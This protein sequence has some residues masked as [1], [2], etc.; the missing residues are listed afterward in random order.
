LV[1][2]VFLVNALFLLATTNFNAGLLL[3]VILG[4]VMLGWGL[5][6]RLLPKA[7]RRLATAAVALAFFVPLGFT[8]GLAAYGLNDNVTG[9]EDAIV[10]LGAAVHGSV[11]SLALSGR[12][13]AAFRLHQANPDALIVV[14]G[15]QGPQEDRA[16]AD[17]MR[18]YLVAWGVP[19]ELIVTEDRATSTA[20]NFAF[21]R[22]LLDALLPPGYTVVYVTHESHVYRAGLIAADAGLAAHHAHTLSTWYVWPSRYLRETAAVLKTWLLGP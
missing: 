20:E 6:R 10:V 11:P 21:S 12:L 4:A 17:V 1:G 16:E 7:L 22:T 18:D 19:E 14:T 8:L 3:E 13:Q 5:F 15:G 2:A 9:D